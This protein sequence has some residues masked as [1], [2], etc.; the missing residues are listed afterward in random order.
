VDP[1]RPP[2]SLRAYDVLW[3]ELH[4]DEPKPLVLDCL[5]PGATHAER[6][7]VAARAWDE[8]AAHGYGRPRA[9]APDVAGALDVLRRPIVELSF[10]SNEIRAIAAGQGPYGTLG[11][12]RD[13]HLELHRLDSAFLAESLVR[14]LPAH[15]PALQAWQHIPAG[16]LAAAGTRL[17]TPDGSSPSYQEILA[18]LPASHASATTRAAFARIATE[19]LVRRA[20]FHG[21]MWDRGVRRRAGES[22]VV[23]DTTFGRYLVIRRAGTVNVGGATEATIIEGL[24]RM[25]VQ[26]VIRR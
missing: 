11:V 14:L 1:M 23:Q 10:R 22:L 21:A 19:P 12:I 18:A 24:R 25:L 26:T 6:V 9:V 4:G 5:S 16:V 13:D 17:R 15:K 2:V 8:L 7:L 20:E 3:S